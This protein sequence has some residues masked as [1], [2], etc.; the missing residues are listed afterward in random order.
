MRKGKF[1]TEQQTVITVSTYQVSLVQLVRSTFTQGNLNLRRNFLLVVFN[2]TSY[3]NLQ[4]KLSDQLVRGGQGRHCDCAYS[5]GNTMNVSTIILMR[6]DR[7]KQCSLSAVLYTCLRLCICVTNC[8]L[9]VDIH[10]VCLAACTDTVPA[11]SPAFSRANG[12]GRE[13]FAGSGNWYSYK[14][15]VKNS[16]SGLE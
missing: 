16:F 10:C 5:P 12:L 8:D 14:P 4:K 9:S 2:C 1:V 13:F 15:Q 3:Q 7:S 11:L 6:P